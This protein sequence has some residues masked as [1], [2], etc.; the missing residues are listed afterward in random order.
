MLGGLA[1]LGAV[2]ILQS[3]A[4]VIASEEQ[5]SRVAANAG[6]LQGG[7]IRLLVVV[8]AGGAASGRCGADGFGAR[9]RRRCWRWW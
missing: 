9:S 6:A 8:L 7:S 4:T 3:V 2:G 5:A 1:L